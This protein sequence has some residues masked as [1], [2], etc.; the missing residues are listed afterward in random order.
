[1]GFWNMFLRIIGFDGMG[2][3]PNPH[4]RYCLH[5]SGRARI[6]F[7]K[8]YRLLPGVYNSPESWQAFHE[9]CEVITATGEFPPPESERKPLTCEELGHKFLAW[10]V[11]Y[12]EG[13]GS[14][15]AV[16]L[17][18]A[19]QAMIDLWGSMLANKFGPPHLKAVRKALIKRGQVRTTVNRRATQIVGV[20]QWAVEEGLLHPEVWQTLK[21]VK[22]IA[23]GREGAVDNP[24]IQPVTATQL[25][26]TLAELP[27]HLQ[28]AL[29]VQALTG[30]RSGELLTMRPQDVTMEGEHWIYR[31]KKHK[32]LRHVGETYVVI[33]RP[34]VEILTECFPTTF[35]DRWFR[36]GVGWQRKAVST[37]AARAGV[38][39]WHPHQLRHN[40]ATEIAEKLGMAAA[41]KI[42]RH[43]SPRTTEGYAKE[44]IEGV[45]AI[46]RLLHPDVNLGG[47]G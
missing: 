15:E 41:Q 44:T 5:S 34:A 31:L 9:L 10:A 12:Y 3:A 16:N 18:Y 37:A 22:R 2:R 46:A 28:R 43:T 11:D 21:S 45:L 20:F 30:M 26:L 6:Y 40:L 35:A 42:L 38:P 47:G 33:P 23:P 29:R 32:T 4:P 25:E 19:V 27:I 14:R 13:E 7:A 8:N 17:S 36:W 1:M 39:A 24:K